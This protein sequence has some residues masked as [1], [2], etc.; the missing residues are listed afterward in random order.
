MTASLNLF[1]DLLR[2]NL[3]DGDCWGKMFFPRISIGFTVTFEEDAFCLEMINCILHNYLIPQSLS[4]L[5][6]VKFKSYLAFLGIVCI[7]HFEQLL[8]CTYT[9]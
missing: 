4:Y 5:S 6:K 8:H 2:V 1:V 9:H 3:R 7:E